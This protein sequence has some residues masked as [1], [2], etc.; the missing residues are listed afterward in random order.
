M[1]QSIQYWTRHP[2]NQTTE[3]DRRNSHTQ[4]LQ[5]GYDKPSAGGRDSDC[6]QVWDKQ[7]DSG[8]DTGLC[9]IRCV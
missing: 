3:G 1:R 2:D 7:D 8:I 5:F 9:I 6:K 4:P